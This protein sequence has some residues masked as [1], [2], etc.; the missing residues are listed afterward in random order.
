[1]VV[2]G[3]DEET[4]RSRFFAALISCDDDGPPA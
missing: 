3:R 1:V 4:R 2:R